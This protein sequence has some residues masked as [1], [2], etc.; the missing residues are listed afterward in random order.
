MSFLNLF[1]KP[2]LIVAHRGS[3]ASS[4]ENTLL[5]LKNSINRCDFIE[6]DVQLSSDKV[7]IIMHDN[8][9]E[10]T[11]NVK[12]IYKNRSSYLVSDFTYQELKKLDYG[13]WFYENE[14]KPEPLLTLRDALKFAKENSVYLNIEI[15]DMD[16]FFNDD[17]VVSTV[18]NEI[19]ISNTQEL[20]LISSFRH[21]YL[22]LCKKLQANIPT[23]ALV[24]KKHPKNL[25]NYLKSLNVDAY[26]F[27]D[28]LVDKKIVDVL[29]DAGIY[30]N[31]YTVNN[32][33]RRQHLFDMGVNGVFSDYL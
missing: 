18:L 8:S 10:R 9:L 3:S 20:V 6:I 15:K 22:P 23:A 13:S 19:K 33:A 16:S 21:E 2:S 5:A 1:K 25:I 7:A 28:Y 24:A 11:T 17:E 29:V 30:I 12:D 27:S 4:P 26:H 31:I 32:L 14:K